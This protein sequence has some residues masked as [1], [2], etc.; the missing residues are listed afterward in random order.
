MTLITGLRC[1]DAVVLASDSQVTVEGGLKTSAQKLFRT[2]QGIIWGTA[3][4][5]AAAQAIAAHFDQLIMDANPGRDAGRQ[6]VKKVVLAAVADLTGTDD[7]LPGGLFK[8]LFA[9]YSVQEQ[10]H[11]LLQARSDGIL[12]LQ[13]QGFAAVGSPSSQ[14]LARFAFFGFTSSRFLEYETLPLEVAKML[15]HTITGDAVDASAQAVDGPIQLAVANATEA[16]VLEE[17]DLKP[18]QDTANAFRMHQAD[19]L[20]RTKRPAEQG[21]ASGLIPGSD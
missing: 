8:G 9:W 17:A 7:R 15:I 5:I 18:V 2:R 16:T 21:G 11:Y 10:Q 6:G 19:F 20:K 12:E 4:S 13:E 3:G 14:E 1:S